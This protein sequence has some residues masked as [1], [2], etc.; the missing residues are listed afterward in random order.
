MLSTPYLFNEIYDVFSKAPFYTIV[1]EVALV[2]IVIWL[3][4]HK[5]KSTGKYLTNEVRLS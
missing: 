4:L 3:I 5:N 2:L 1:L